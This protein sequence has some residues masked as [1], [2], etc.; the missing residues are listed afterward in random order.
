MANA[1]IEEVSESDPSEGDISELS[2]NEFDEREIIK[3]RAGYTGKPTSSQPLTSSSLIDTPRFPPV[4]NSSHFK[5][6]QCIYPVYFDKLRSRKQ[7]RMVASELAV[8]NPMARGIADICGRLGLETLF[9]PSK[10]HPKDWANPG[11][12]R[13][14]LKGE[15]HLYI[16]ISKYLKA[17]PTTIDTAKTMIVPGVPSPDPTKPY[18]TPAVPKGW[19]MG[20][21]LPY[22]SPAISDGGISEGFFKEMMAQMQ[23]AGGVPTGMPG[24]PGMP[25]LSS[26]QGILGGASPS[27]ST[28]NSKKPRKK[29]KN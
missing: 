26:L 18:P 8:E 19:I 7:G 6:F 27:S 29:G 23:S 10:I 2:D 24:M 17:E 4:E 14:N 11:R 22:H 13:V 25:D 16:L 1:R 28:P 5:N 20:S 12:V 9:E 21:I 3:T 15:H